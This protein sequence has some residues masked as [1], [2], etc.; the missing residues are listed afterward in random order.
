MYYYPQ[1]IRYLY[2]FLPVFIYYFYL[3]VQHSLKFVRL[4]FNKTI[5][6]TLLICMLAFFYKYRIEQSVVRNRITGV[7]D[8]AAQNM[9]QFI[10][11]HYTSQ[12]VFCFMKPRALALYTHVKTLHYPWALQNDQEVILNFKKFHVTH[13]MISFDQND[14]LS[15]FIKRNAADF[16]DPIKIEYFLIYTFKKGV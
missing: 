7:K 1:G 8:I 13:L 5:G 11:D 2:P 4:P 14:K 12:D 15:D 6:A 3:G 10:N 16:E 9:F